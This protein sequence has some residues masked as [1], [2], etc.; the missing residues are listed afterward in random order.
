M[1]SRLFKFSAKLAFMSLALV[2]LLAGCSKDDN[3]APTPGGAEPTYEVQAT[4]TDF[5]TNAAL[6]GAYVKVFVLYCCSD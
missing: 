4:I 1:R 2:G 5:A 3:D 6:Q